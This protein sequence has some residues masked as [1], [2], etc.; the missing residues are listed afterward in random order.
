[1]KPNSILASLLLIVS[2][3]AV[4]ELGL[5]IRDARNSQEKLVGSIE[6][7]IT[8]IHGKAKTLNQYTAAQ[9]EVFNSHENRQM[10]QALRDAAA[11]TIK[12]LRKVDQ[13][14]VPELNATIA[15]LKDSAVGLTGVESSLNALVQNTDTSLNGGL[16]PNVSNVVVKLSLTTETLDKSIQEAAGETNVALG[17]IHRILSDPAIAASQQQ[18]LAILT[19]ADASMQHVEKSM[20]YV[21][22][23][24]SPKKA[25][26]WAKL[27]S[28]FIP[29][30]TVR[31]N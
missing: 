29:K 26:F 30:L 11:T 27:L 23:Y 3:F 8:E 24:L 20:G 17:D 1:M 14:T 21:E 22:Q 10:Q 15:A 31:M 9:A 2:I 5:F 16:L 28:L 6:S 25:T 12:I 19:H 18:A 13:K 7:T 4:A